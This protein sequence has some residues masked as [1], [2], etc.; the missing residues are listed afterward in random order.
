MRQRVVL[1]FVCL[2]ALLITLPVG[3]ADSGFAGFYAPQPVAAPT[4]TPAPA[5]CS[6]IWLSNR[7][8]V[9][10]ETVDV[11]GFASSGTGPN[12]I[13]AFRFSFGDGGDTGWRNVGGW[14]GAAGSATTY[15]TPGFYQVQFFV[16]LAGGQVLGGIN[17][18]CAA[19][20]EVGSGQ[21]TATATLPPPTATATVTA[22]PTRTPT[23]TDT[24]T[25]TPTPTE[26]DTPTVTPTATATE[27]ATPTV[28][29]TTT[30][31]ETTT[32]TVTPTATATETTTPT[33][34]PTA[35]A[36]TTALPS[37]TPTPTHPAGMQPS[38]TPE[39]TPTQPATPTATSTLAPGKSATA[40]PT[41]APVD[42]VQGAPTETTASAATPTL[43]PPSATPTLSPTAT[44]TQTASPTP[45]DTP[46]LVKPAVALPGSAQRPQLMINEI[47][48]SGPPTAEG[49][50]RPKALAAGYSFAAFGQSPQQTTTN[51]SHQWIE[52]Y[53]RSGQAYRMNG[54]TLETAAGVH[55]IPETL[56]P[57]NSFIIL[58]WNVAQFA[59]DFAQVPASVIQLEG[60]FTDVAG[61]NP[62]GDHVLL[63][64]PAGK[65][66]S[67]LSYGNDATV[68]SAPPPVVPGGHTVERNPVGRDTGT[69]NDFVDR[70]P[71]TPGGPAAPWILF[72][73][74][75]R[76]LPQLETRDNFFT[77]ITT[78][79]EFLGTPVVVLAAN[80]LLAMIMALVFGVCNTVTDNLV[81]DQ[82][83]T[84]TNLLARV[85][86]VAGLLAWLHRASAG[87]RTVDRGIGALAKLGAILTLYAVLACFLDPE[88]TL[89][90]PG[91]VFFFGVMLVTMAICGY[92]DSLG[93][94]FTLRRWKVMHR[95]D[96]W[97]ANLFVAAGAV[98]LSRIVPLR[99]G[100]LFGAPGGVGV[101]DSEL[102]PQRKVTLRW[103]G[104]GAMITL[105]VAAWVASG[106]FGELSVRLNG[107]AQ[108]VTRIA[109]VMI[110]LQNLSLAIFLVSLQNL[111]F[112]MIPVATTYGRDLWH[113]KHWLW[114]VV[115]IPAAMALSRILI[116]P[117]DGPATAFTRSP[118]QVLLM[119][120]GGYLL[121]TGSL[122][123]YFRYHERIRRA[124]RKGM[125]AR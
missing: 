17:T 9:T 20:I 93:Q 90:G 67:K 71:P 41:S 114:W 78:P 1:P 86:V 84:L 102:T 64:D 109:H 52:L 110:A 63:R 88:W 55:V 66:V 123:F 33:V 116:N 75:A 91:G 56:V 101:E 47:S 12:A 82:E 118:V 106:L 24:P 48:F 85:P 54:W 35:T 7:A 104:L 120:L 81:R 122:W 119:F 44:V 57:G 16:R 61:F 80:L 105:V 15:N 5:S 36:S 50:A 121:F 74:P 108:S 38:A 103:A 113:K 39:P 70:Y 83:S 6:F 60:D 51:T 72:N 111:F 2:V 29:P 89:L 34:T 98:L 87:G 73:A 59:N 19:A 27:T 37:P 68:F 49:P 65:V 79:W 32:P 124:W 112:T 10:G 11:N 43:A 3:A 58:A 23:G 77:P 45:A 100:L 8:P 14:S 4:A 13:V 117:D 26:T 97:P 95:F 42:V 125:A 31:T 69:A 94:S 30:A 115:F 99:P 21:P 22:V 62:D 53:N 40:S 92:T 28:T 96:F 76:L 25:I 18:Q 46:L 107:D